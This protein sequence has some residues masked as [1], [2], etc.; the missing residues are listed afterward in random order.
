MAGVPNRASDKSRQVKLLVTNGGLGTD[1]QR[2]VNYDIGSWQGR[3][4]MRKVVDEHAKRTGKTSHAETFSY[5]DKNPIHYE[6]KV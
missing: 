3:N 6:K 4:A 5:K 2:I 1:N